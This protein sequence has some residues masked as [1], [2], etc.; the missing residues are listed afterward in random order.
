MRKKRKLDFI[1]EDRDDYRL[2]FRFYP[3]SS[4]CHSFNENPPKSWNEVYK[5]YYFYSV[6]IQWKNENGKVE[7]THT[8]FDSECDECSI[9]DEVGYRCQLIA[10]GITESKVCDGDETFSLINNDIFPMGMGVSWVI[11][12]RPE[13]DLFQ[14]EMYRWDNIGYRFIVNREKLKEFGQFLIDCCE[15]MLV[16]GQS[17]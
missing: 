13:R 6:L 2:I 17:I 8:L 15:Y 4:T 1:I 7:Q 5:V 16:H 3:K 9:I 11:R 10:D 14:L 12:I